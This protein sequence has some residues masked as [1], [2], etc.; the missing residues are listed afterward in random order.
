M[1]WYTCIVDTSN[2]IWLAVICSNRKTQSNFYSNTRNT[3]QIHIHGH[4][5]GF[6]RPVTLYVYTNYNFNNKVI[7]YH[8]QW[9]FKVNTSYIVTIHSEISILSKLSYLILNQSAVA[10]PGVPGL[11]PPF[12]LAHQCIWMGAYSWNPLYSGLGTPP[13]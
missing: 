8:L 9:L 7:Q 1:R 4:D 12:F 2:N 10:D 11:E 3:A 6:S 5:G 13:F